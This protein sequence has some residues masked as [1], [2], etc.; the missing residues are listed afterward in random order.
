MKQLLLPLLALALL[1][2]CH[3]DGPDPA[4]TLPAATQTGA[5]TFGCRVNGEVWLPKGNTGRAN[6]VALYDPDPKGAVLNIATYRIDGRQEFMNLFC[7][8]ITPQK[9][10]FTIGLPPQTEAIG[11]YDGFYGDYANNPALTY[12]KGQINLTRVDEQAGVLAG[13]FW[14]SS[15]RRGSTDTLKVTDGRFDYKL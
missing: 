6:S 4:T 13:T 12:L 3:K 15:V 9:H 7:A 1:T 14:F 5:N 2:Q 10:V 11:H 8:P